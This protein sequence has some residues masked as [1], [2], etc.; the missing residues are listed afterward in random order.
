MRSNV[1]LHLGVY[2]YTREALLNWVS[3]P[4]TPAEFDHGLEQLRP[5]LHGIPIGVAVLHEVV[6]HGIDTTRDLEN[7]QN[8]LAT[9]RTNA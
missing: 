7:A 9:T 1:H 5:I 4:P 8:S 2:A 3:L 6:E